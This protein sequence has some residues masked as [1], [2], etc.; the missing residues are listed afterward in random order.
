MQRE[1]KK[2]KKTR[3][4]EKRKNFY[5]FFLALI[6]VYSAQ[7]GSANKRI[8]NKKKKKRKKCFLPFFFFFIC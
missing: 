8:R 2:E 1:K 7:R 6:K 3:W 4:A 5:L